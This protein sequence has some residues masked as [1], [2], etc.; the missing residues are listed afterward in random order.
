MPDLWDDLPPEM[1]GDRPPADCLSKEVVAPAEVLKKERGE[2]TEG[3][4]RQVLGS[5]EVK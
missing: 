2:D 4:L 1:M 5:P 3:K